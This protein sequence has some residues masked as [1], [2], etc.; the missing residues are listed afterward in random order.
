MIEQALVNLGTMIVGV[1][2]GTYIATKI[3]KREL[4]KE[5]THYII[6]DL[7]HLLENERFREQARN[8]ARV[9]I[10]ELGTIIKEELGL[11]KKDDLS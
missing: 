11:E 7:P 9:F 2:L 4:K 8:L 10:R 5:I 1:L 6:N 3:T